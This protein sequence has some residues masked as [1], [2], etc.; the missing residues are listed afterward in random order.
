MAAQRHRDVWVC[1]IEKDAEIGAHIL[2][3]AAIEPRALDELLPDWRTR[4]VPLISPPHVENAAYLK[5]KQASMGH[6][7][8]RIT[9]ETATK[10]SGHEPVARS[11]RR[12]E[13]S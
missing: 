8:P 7:Y 12:V 9:A 10:A 4:G 3:G 5:A 6:L 2:S 13:G 11:A 1:L